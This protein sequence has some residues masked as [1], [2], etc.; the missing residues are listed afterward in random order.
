MPGKGV[1][2]EAVKEK[3]IDTVYR[4][5]LPSIILLNKDK[6]VKVVLWGREI[7]KIQG[8]KTGKKEP[9]EENIMNAKCEPLNSGA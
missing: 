2:G 8:N 3:V 7:I 5:S 1:G 6:F 4:S 9:K